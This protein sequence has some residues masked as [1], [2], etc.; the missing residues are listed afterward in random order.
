[1]VPGREG[2]LLH[3]DKGNRKADTIADNLSGY[4][5]DV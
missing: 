3:E 1:M 5:A 2:D 4:M